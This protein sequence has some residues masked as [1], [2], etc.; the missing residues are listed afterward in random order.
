LGIPGI[1]NVAVWVDRIVALFGSKT[2]I[3][4]LDT[5]PKYEVP[6]AARYENIVVPSL[7][8]VRMTDRFKTLLENDMHVLQLRPGAAQL[9]RQV[10]HPLALLRVRLPQLVHLH[11]LLPLRVLLRR[12]LLLL[13]ARH[14]LGRVRLP[15]VHQLVQSLLVREQVD[16]FEKGDQRIK[17]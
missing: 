13:G 4:W 2:W 7:D 17:N 5:I 8:S 14:E 1:S 11:L 12:Q 9:L 15:L 6:K 3:P 10:L 16:L